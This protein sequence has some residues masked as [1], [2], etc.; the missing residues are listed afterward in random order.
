MWVLSI[1]SDFRGEEMIYYADQLDMIDDKLFQALLPYV[2]NER[3]AV[4]NRYRFRADCVQSVLAFILLRIG[5][6]EEYGISQVPGIATGNGK[7]PYLTEHPHIHFNLSH[8][9]TGVACAL[10][11]A[12]IGIDIQHYVDYKESVARKI[13]TPGEFSFCNR[14]NREFTRIW[15]LKE[16]Y[17]KYLGCGIR[18]DMAKHEVLDSAVS[19][20]YVLRDFVLCVSTTAELKLVKI[21]ADELLTRCQMLQREHI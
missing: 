8:C 3:M 7:K 1:V 19:K 21:Q 17:G 20:S 11:D 16:S 4:A 13:M 15:S 5:L 18:Y 9:K 12:P 2:S 6:W 14:D 10:S